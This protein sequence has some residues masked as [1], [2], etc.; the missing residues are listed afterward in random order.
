[1]KTKIV[2]AKA[3]VIATTSLKIG[4]LYEGQVLRFLTMPSQGNETLKPVIYFYIWG[5]PESY[6]T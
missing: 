5:A 2:A 4:T 6:Q 3:P 1:M